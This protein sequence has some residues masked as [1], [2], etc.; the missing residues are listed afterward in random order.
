MIQKQLKLRLKA[1]QERQLSNWLFQ[2]T[3]VWNWAIRQIELDAKD[4]IFYTPKAFH[5]LLANHSKKLD[6]PSH[7]LQGMLSTTYAAWQRCF[8]KLAKR[9]KLKGQRHKLALW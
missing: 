5:N 2:L 3:G 6:I 9:P 4:G 1:R 7:T 8:K